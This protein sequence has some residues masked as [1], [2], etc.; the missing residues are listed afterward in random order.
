MKLNRIPAIFALFTIIFFIQ[1]A[2]LNRIN[3]FL[4]GFSLYLA[5]FFAWI[6]QENRTAAIS[7]GFI[8]GLIA[9]F[10]PTLEAPF[11]LWTFVLTLMAFAFSTV[12]R[13]T[14]EFEFSPLSITIATVLGSTLAL[15]FFLICGLI[16]G[17]DFA[18]F[19]VIF[20]NLVGNAFWSFILSPLFVPAT[21]KVQRLSLSARDK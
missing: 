17:V 9:D 18:S 19:S 20:K 14:L 6:I 11:G 3:F 1:E 5:F 7:I 15:I 12:L 21:K 4:G 16:L 2:F 8:A 10:S 13:G